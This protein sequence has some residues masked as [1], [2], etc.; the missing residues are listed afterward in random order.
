LQ[1]TVIKIDVEPDDVVLIDLEREPNGLDLNN[2]SGNSYLVT[3]IQ[4]NGAEVKV[5]E[6]IDYTTSFTERGAASK[7]DSAQLL[8][9]NSL[10]VDQTAGVKLTEGWSYRWDE[11]DFISSLSSVL[12]L[13]AMI[14]QAYLGKDQ[15]VEAT[16]SA[17]AE[18][19][20]RYQLG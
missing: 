6:R 7:I 14:E 16:I 9:P 13:W 5:G 1:R 17:V 8:I 11:P 15:K 4:E 12:S 20:R 3:V 10:I 2:V 19:N 18:Q